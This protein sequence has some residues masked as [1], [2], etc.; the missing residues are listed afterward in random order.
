MT[1]AAPERKPLS[2]VDEAPPSTLLKSLIV[3]FIVVP[4][5]AVIA[6]IPVAWQGWLSC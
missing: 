5:M 4:L 3:L 1:T 6:A 2:D